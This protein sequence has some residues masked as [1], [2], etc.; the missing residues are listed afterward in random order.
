MLVNGVPLI[1]QGD[2]NNCAVLVILECLDIIF[3]PIVVS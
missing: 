1:S 3:M 2:W